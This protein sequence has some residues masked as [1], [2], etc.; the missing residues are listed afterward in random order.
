MPG[1][2][3]PTVIFDSSTLILF[4][5]DAL[6]A[7]A[8]DL[9]DACQLVAVNAAIAEDGARIR[10]ET[11][12]KLPDA[13]IAATELLQSA[14]R[15]TANAKGY[16]RVPG[17]T[18]T[19]SSLYSRVYLPHA[20]PSLF[21]LISKSPMSEFFLQLWSPFFEGKIAPPSPGG[22]TCKSR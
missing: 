19:A 7:D 3:I 16:R 15:A 4:L 21:L 5:N 2:T 20:C 12:L 10:R 14:T 18:R 17:L 8:L 9:L 1:I 6:P 22:V 11:G 13:L